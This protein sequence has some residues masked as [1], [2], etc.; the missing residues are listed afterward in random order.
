MSTVL[1]Y[2]VVDAES[3]D[4]LVRDVQERISQGW[5]PLGA[6]FY[7]GGSFLQAVVWTDDSEERMVGT[8]D[9]AEDAQQDL[10]LIEELTEVD[11]P[12]RPF[13]DRF[14]YTPPGGLLG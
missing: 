3:V 7:L 14:D 12:I 13:S 10:D 4:R 1:K 8:T 9:P 2:D 11:D 6:P 5:Q